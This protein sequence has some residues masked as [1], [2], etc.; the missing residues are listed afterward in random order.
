MLDLY[1]NWGVSC[2]SLGLPD[3]AIEY[4]EHA[5][6]LAPDHTESHY[7][8]GIAYSSI[9]RIEEARR[10]MALGMQLEKEGGRK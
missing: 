9:G 3:K 7:N 2:Y 4:L 1:N 10:E 6:R 5:V 8:L